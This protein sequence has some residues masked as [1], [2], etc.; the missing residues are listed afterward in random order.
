MSPIC[1]C[2]T[3]VRQRE[4]A[5]HQRPPGAARKRLLRQFLTEAFLLSLLGGGL[6]VIAAYLELQSCS[7]SRKS[8]PRLDNTSASAMP[9]CWSSHFCSRQWSPL[10]WASSPQRLQSDRAKAS[11]A[12][13][14][15]TKRARKQF[16]CW[17]GHCCGANRHHFGLV[18]GAG[19]LGAN[20]LKVAGLIQPSDNIVTM[21]V[22][23]G[24]R[25]GKP[26]PQRHFLFTFDGP[27][28]TDSRRVRAVGATSGL[29]MVDGGLPRW[30]CFC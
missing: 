27:P 9:K 5:I 23:F 13:V 15:R 8:I 7:R 16:A 11:Q 26:K 30:R 3:S 2:Q 24:H 28:Q 12:D 4:L 17:S 25:V 18:V 21:D 14:R 10:P 29:P 22:S 1:S 19:L 6:I 20:L